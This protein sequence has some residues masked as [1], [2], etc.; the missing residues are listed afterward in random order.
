MTSTR[1][2]S[3]ADIIPNRA[4]GYV[5]NDDAAALNNQDW[6]SPAFNSTADGALYFN[7]LDL[8]KWDAALYTTR[9]LKQSSLQKMWTVYR[10]NNGMPNPAHYGFAWRINQ[11]NER[12]VLEHSG[13][14]QGFTCNISRYPNDSLAVVVLTNLD[15][16]HARPEYMAQV[17][18]GL[19]DKPL[20]P[21]NLTAIPDDRPR[22]AASLASVL[23]ALSD[24][25]NLRHRVAPDFM[26]S[27]GPGSIASI[28]RLIAPLW[29]GGRLQLVERGPSP[30]AGGV[31]LSQFRLTKGPRSLLIT[32][33]VNAR[34]KADM[35]FLEPD[36]EYRSREI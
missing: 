31:M 1:L 33:S 4:A 34:G 2:I 8:A 10:L 25:T 17:I 27:I 12:L 26:D 32:Y 3:E 35:L 29:P 23:D 13:A 20:L 5:W 7:V 6:V 18:A 11:Q 24:R 9:L 19:V 36:E 30:E 22:I 28:R 21:Q 15:S 14:W 16:A